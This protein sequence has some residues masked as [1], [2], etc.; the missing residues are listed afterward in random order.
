M[1]II[2]KGKQSTGEL[3]DS[4]LSIL[5]IFNSRYGIRNFNEI[6]LH[7]T[8][9]DDKNKIVELIDA[10]TSEPIRIF[11]VSKVAPSEENDSAPSYLNLI[12]DNTKEED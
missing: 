8:L 12:V 10:E 9:L 3:A 4:M 1:H 6:N 2:F 7:V 5:K 11:E